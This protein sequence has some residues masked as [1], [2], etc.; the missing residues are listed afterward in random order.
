MTKKKSLHIIILF[1][2]VSLFGDFVYEGA[3]SVNG[4]Y[5]KTLGASAAVVGLFAG[6][7]EFLGYATRFFSGYLSDRTRSYWLFVFFGY[8]L[9]VSVPLL[10]IA[11]TWQAAMVFIILERFGKA[12]RGPARDTI[13]S[14]ASSKIGTGLGFGITEVFDQI[15]AISG[16]LLLSGFLF[17]S[18]ASPDKQI[19]D[20][21]RGYSLFWVPFFLLAVCLWLAYRWAPN[22]ADLETADDHAGAKEPRRFSRL[23]WLYTAFTFITTAGFANVIL[24]GYHFKNDHLFADAVIPL[25]YALAMAVDAIT[26][27]VIGKAYDVLKMRYNNKVKGLSVLAVLPMLSVLI[28]IC[29]FSKTPLM[30][31]AGMALWG[32]VMGIHETIM[33]SAIA[34]ITPVAKRG[35]AYG[36]FNAGYGVAIFIGSAVM[37]YLYDVSLPVLITAVAAVEAAAMIIFFAM[38]GEM[39]LTERS[40]A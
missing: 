31:I 32:V 39:L 6:L 17:F 8:A 15:G 5:L 14:M 24:I 3:R 7:G 26:A 13:V 11:G 25:L 30:A 4:P 33:R 9:I 18:N 29:A 12:I 35:T 2:L 34:D 22:P 20:Y 40:A 16:P 38:R 21:Q 37:G 10:S 19:N 27:I 23:F 36:V 1:G 28:T